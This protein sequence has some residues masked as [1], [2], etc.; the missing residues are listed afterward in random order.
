M[1]QKNQSFPTVMNML[2]DVILL[3]AAYLAAVHLRFNVL[4]G[5]LSVPL[6]S[7]RI[8]RLAILY[9]IVVVL[10]YYACSIYNHRHFRRHSRSVALLAINTVG[11]LALATLFFVLRLMDFSRWTLVFFWLFSNLFII[12]K[13]KLIRCIEKK[14]RSGGHNLRH[15]AIVGNGRLAAQCIRD[16]NADP[17]LGIVVDGYISAVEK[18]DLGTCLGSYEELEEI[19]IRHRLDCLIVALEAHETRFLRDVLTLAEKEGARVELIPF[20]NDYLPT[21]PVIEAVGKTKMINLRSTPLDNIGWAVVK[22][23]MDII[24]S[25]FLILI[26]SPIMLVTAIGVKLSS[27]GPVLFRQERVGKNKEPFMML[28]F[29]SMR[30]DIDHT[31]WSTDEDPRKTKFGSFIRKFS[32]DELPQAFN[33][34]AGQ[35]SLV[36]PRPEIP[37]YVRQFRE[38]V[39]LYLVRQQIRPGMTGWAQI[40]GLRGDTSIEARVEYDIWYIE[41]WS[42]RL[43]IRILLKTV[44]GSFIN[45]EK[46]TA[47]DKKR[48]DDTVSV[49]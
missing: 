40:H 37:R 46:L 43:D 36:G 49:S 21:H 45:A 12:G 16:I 14:R 26:T 8:L 31:G 25:L 9:S 42:L 7:G 15:V 38:E 13:H 1:I 11:T 22:R 47:K 23:A 18:P 5:V 20:Y 34:L 41:N 28:K 35:M 30:N 17:E 29:R 19:L 10:V 44:F 32:I 3:I 4:D 39:P 48:E 6:S 27:P 33:V 24:G 2:S